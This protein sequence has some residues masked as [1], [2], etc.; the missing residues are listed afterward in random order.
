MGMFAAPHFAA[1]DCL[2]SVLLSAGG[3]KRAAREGEGPP[4]ED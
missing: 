2:S 1:A 4:A 3:D